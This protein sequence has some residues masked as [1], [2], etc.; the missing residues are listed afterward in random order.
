MKIN[1]L[2][3]SRIIVQILFVILLFI[4]LFF[5][6]RPIF[7]AFLLLALLAGNFYC[8]WLCP[9]G[10][11]QEIF[12]RL[13]SLFIKNKYKMPYSI[14]K[15]LQFSRYILMI[16]FIVILGNNSLIASTINSYKIFIIISSGNTVE[17]IALIIMVSFLLISLFFER[18]FCNYFCSE[19]IKYAVLSLGRI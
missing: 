15:Y 6:I 19:G 11:V 2:Q 18:P 14:Q 12:G 5:K 16:S 9:F 10:T 7:G 4:G 17:I 13:G 3:L 1:K 8:G